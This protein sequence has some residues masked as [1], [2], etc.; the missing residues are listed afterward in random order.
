MLYPVP[1]SPVVT[2]FAL[3][4]WGNQAQIIHTM[5]SYI[6]NCSDHRKGSRDLV[7]K[8][9]I[10]PAPSESMGKCNGKHNCLHAFTKISNKKTATQS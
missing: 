8:N 10:A 1:P 7:R 2:S 4:A 6:Y 9:M 5:K 3:L